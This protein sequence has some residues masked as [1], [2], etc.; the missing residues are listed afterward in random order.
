MGFKSRNNIA[1]LLG[2]GASIPAGIPSTHEL[3]EIIY[4][5]N[6]ICRN[7]NG[8]YYFGPPQF[9][10]AKEI[11]VPAIVQFLNRIKIE[12]A[13]AREKLGLILSSNYEDNYYSC[14]QIMDCITGEYENPL[15]EP[16]ITKLQDDLNSNRLFADVDR[17]IYDLNILGLCKETT[18]YIYD[19]V[20]NKLARKPT[21]LSH[22]Q[23]INDAK[24]DPDIS[25]ISIYTTNHDIHIEEY[26]NDSSIRYF[27]GFYIQS[28]YLK[29]W[30]PNSYFKYDN[31][32]MLYK[33][34]GSVNW[35][36]FRP[37]GGSWIDEFYGIPKKTINGLLVDS[38]EELIIDNKGRYLETIDHRPLLLIGTTNKILDYSSGLF[39]D[40]FSHVNFSLKQTEFLIISGYGFGDRGINSLIIE[41][42]YSSPDRTILV[43]HNDPEKLFDKS[44][45]S[46]KYKYRDWLMSNKLLL[47]RKQ[48]QNVSWRE[49]KSKI[50]SST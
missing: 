50:Y 47:I 11:Y 16:F 23:F 12:E 14:H 20:Y 34:H 6:G 49:M 40:I 22:L 35:Y 29:I 28:P 5:G 15:L 39:L 3:S 46:I 26:F 9:E 17:K 38:N 1:F 21:S 25:R 7:S 42:L 31:Q 48:L 13:K 30:N 24:C 2:S 19:I 10:N 45:P 33:L 36:R 8:Y 32:I 4:Q 44:K 41:W 37:V 43:I 27:D 18:D